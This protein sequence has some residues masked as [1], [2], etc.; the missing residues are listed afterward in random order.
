MEEHTVLL[1]RPLARIAGEASPELHRHH[2]GKPPGFL[3]LDDL[4]VPPDAVR[5]QH[6]D[7][8]FVRA[9]ARSTTSVSEEHTGIRTS[10]WVQS[11]R[12]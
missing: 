3:R 1:L 4:A 8:R 7:V 11:S 2:N 12:I 5:L 6:Q 9:I 10:G